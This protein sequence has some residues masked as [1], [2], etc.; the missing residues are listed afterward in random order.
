MDKYGIKI[1]L[2]GKD[3]SD[4]TPEECF[5]T[6]D[7]PC[8]KIKLKQVPAHFGV[9]THT[10]ASTPATGETA[11]FTLNHNLGYKPMHFCLIK[12]AVSGVNRA[13]PLPAYSGVSLYIYAYVSTTQFKIL[14]NRAVGGTDPTGE[15]W[16]FKY[17]IFV[18]NGA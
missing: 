18:E 15:T 1:V 3:V 5:V 7:Y 16:V 12:Y 2:P 8:P 17:Y 11:L 4:A 14:I 10:F 6:P 13:L 9:Y